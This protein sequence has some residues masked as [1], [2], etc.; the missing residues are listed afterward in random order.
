MSTANYKS[1]PWETVQGGGLSRRREALKEL[2]EVGALWG[3]AD[4]MSLDL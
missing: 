1:D 4:L 3:R 2:D